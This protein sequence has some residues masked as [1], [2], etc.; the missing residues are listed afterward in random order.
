MYVKRS[1]LAG[2]AVVAAAFAGW[3]LHN[4]TAPE[5]AT[6]AP[7]VAAAAPAPAA[8]APAPAVPTVDQADPTANRPVVDHQSRPA[9]LGRP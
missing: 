6:A 2:L 7:A 3:A 4:A 1:Y 9:H 8:A 5:A